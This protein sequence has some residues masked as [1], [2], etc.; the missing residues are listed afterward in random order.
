MRTIIQ[1]IFIFLLVIWES[2]QCTAMKY[3]A[4]ESENSGIRTVTIPNPCYQR[5]SDTE[6]IIAGN[7]DML[8]FSASG[9]I[10]WA[11]RGISNLN[12][13]QNPLGLT[14][15]G[16]GILERP[17]WLHETILRLTPSEEN[18]GIDCQISERA[19]NAMLREIQSEYDSILR[20]AGGG[21]E[22]LYPFIIEANGTADAVLQGI[23]PHVQMRSLASALSGY[24]GTAYQRQVLVNIPIEYTRNFVETNIGKPYEG[25][26]SFQE[27]FRAAI[28]GRNREERV[29]RLFCSELAGLFYRG[30]IE[31]YCMENEYL[32]SRSG[33]FHNVSN[34]IPEQFCSQLGEID[35]LNGLAGSEILLKSAIANDETRCGNCSVS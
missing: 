9:P 7:G 16:V 31:T 19:G 1:S 35:L 18:V 17:T 15:S 32:R 14:H 34:I 8:N 29:D 28:G 33:L 25:L 2:F 22:P 12:D 10:G 11:I 26:G 21:N 13:I 6:H 27:L 30:V 4:I 5:Y 24:D 3:D 20:L 23:Y